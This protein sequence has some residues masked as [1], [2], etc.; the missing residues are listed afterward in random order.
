MAVVIRTWALR[1]GGRHRAEGFDFCALTHCQVFRLAQGFSGRH[2]EAISRAIRE[3]EGQVLEY[4]GELADPYFS[5][6]CGGV[7]ESAGNVWPDKA[8]PYLQALPDP[9]CGASAHSSWQ[10]T[11]SIDSLGTI[12][13]DDVGA[14]I[15]GPLR[16]VAVASRDS[17]G[18]ARTL[19]IEADARF[20]IDANQFRYAV[21]RRLG[22][23]EIKS[24]LYTAQ[25]RGDNL[26]FTGRGLG[27]GVGLCQAGAD[28]MGR[29]GISY[30]RILAQYFP[31]ATVVRLPFPA[32]PDPVA[33]SEHFELAFPEGQRRWVSQSLS[34]LE[35]S[36][37]ELAIP[38]D[39][40]PPRVPVE[41][42]D[43]TADF[44]QA[45]GKPS[46]VAG[47]TDG[48]S[49]LLQPLGT[50]TAKGILT[51]TLRHELAHVALH[52][53]CA[54]GLPLWLEEGLA[55]YLTGERIDTGTQQASSRRT[56]GEV[57]ARSRSEAEMHEAYARAALLVRSLA[58]RRGQD[59]L[60]QVLEHPSEAD[61]NW[62]NRESARPLGP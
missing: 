31:G 39:A 50:L 22:W 15:R 46:W 21:D 57:V 16:G 12:L 7:S 43:R 8:I 56:L 36:R 54:R 14:V 37:R 10:R 6:D 18:R 48:N 3:T 44:I 25:R 33:S 9:Y 49:I 2:S 38:A 53:L 40:W 4:K 20:L 26:V 60:W 59:A 41:T 28:A 19:A 34:E 45:T 62:L 5:A 17:S 55:L 13:R 35:R 32:T 1:Y 61:R 24:N 23:G 27:H 52:R 47:A 30:M 11:I 58:A 42:W 29:L 51:A